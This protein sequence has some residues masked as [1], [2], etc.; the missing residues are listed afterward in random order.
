MLQRSVTMSKTRIRHALRQP[1]IYTIKV[2]KFN[3]EEKAF[4]G[5]LP[6]PYG[7]GR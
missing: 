7:G 2:E 3:A 5:D 6:T 1:D 4:A